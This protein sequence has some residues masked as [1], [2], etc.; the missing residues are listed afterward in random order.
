MNHFYMIKIF[1][2]VLVN[3]QRDFIML[4]NLFTRP[5]LL[6][7]STNNLHSTIAL[8]QI[9]NYIVNYISTKKPYKEYDYV[10]SFEYKEVN[11]DVEVRY[12]ITIDHKGNL[13]NLVFVAKE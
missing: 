3:K 10:Y 1:N 6:E 13:D 7:L 9:F 11:P 12:E 2:I 5:I 8:H 4:S